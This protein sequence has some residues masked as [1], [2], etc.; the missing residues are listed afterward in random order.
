MDNHNERGSLRSRL[1]GTAATT[2]FLVCASATGLGVLSGADDFTAPAIEAVTLNAPS[3]LIARAD[4]IASADALSDSE[5]APIRK[6][7][8]L[9]IT[10]SETDTLS[11]GLR[12]LAKR[13]PRFAITYAEGMDAKR[14]P[15]GVASFQLGSTRL[16][17]RAKSLH[18]SVVNKRFPTAPATVAMQLSTQDLDDG[19]FVHTRDDLPTGIMTITGQNAQVHQWRRF[20]PPI[21]NTTPPTW[22]GGPVAQAGPAVGASATTSYPLTI[23][24]IDFTKV[25][26]SA[27]VPLGGVGFS[28]SWNEHLDALAQQTNARDPHVAFEYYRQSLERM[29]QTWSSANVVWTTIPLAASRNGLRNAFNAN[30]RSYAS[31]HGKPLLD[32]AA[33]QSTGDDGQPAVDAEGER[34]QPAWASPGSRSRMNMNGAVRTAKA[35]WWI[36]AKLQPP[37]PMTAAEK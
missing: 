9:V 22:P 12:E 19:R 26:T 2:V 31:A 16:D 28:S 37:P 33:I 4:A 8:G 25:Q 27:V 34:S 6:Q 32:I 3:T 5:L 36:Q 20:G 35:W 30:V 10:P 24:E 7:I 21:P 29:E 23:P 15:A 14:M 17:N 11:A 1:R 13:E 18:Q